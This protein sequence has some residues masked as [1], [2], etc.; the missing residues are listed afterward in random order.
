MVRLWVIV[1]CYFV[2][3]FVAIGLLLLSIS[4]TLW[5]DDFGGLA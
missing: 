5:F 2:F 1:F 3:V 4:G